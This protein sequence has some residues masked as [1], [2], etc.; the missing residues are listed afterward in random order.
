MRLMDFLSESTPAGVISETGQKVV[1]GI[2][3]GVKDLINEFHMSPEQK[4]QL[5]LK[6]A[7]LE[8][9]AI[10][11]QV[12]DVQSARAM[13]I[14]MHSVW[15]GILSTIITLGFFVALGAIVTKGLPELDHNGGQ[16]VLILL[17]TLT[18]GFTTV[19]TFWLGTS[20][21]SQNKDA[22]IWQSMPVTHKPAPKPP[23]S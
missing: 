4:A 11:E 23:Q 12:Q 5:D 9:A 16:A 3:T 17:G 13:Q 19:I 20:R 2:F 21:Q 6:L 10:K 14:Q 7:E 8:L 22:M 15:P 18:A 1:S